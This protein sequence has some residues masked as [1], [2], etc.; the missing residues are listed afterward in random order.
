MNGGYKTIGNILGL[1]KMAYGVR[2]LSIGHAFKH[3]DELFIGLS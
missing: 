3:G 1:Y 2:I